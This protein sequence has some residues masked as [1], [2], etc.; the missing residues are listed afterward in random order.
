MACGVKGKRDESNSFGWG[1][2]LVRLCLCQLCFWS[3]FR[4]LLPWV[5]GPWNMSMVRKICVFV[6]YKENT[7]YNGLLVANR[8][9]FRTMNFPGRDR[10]DFQE[11]DHNEAEDTQVAFH[12]RTICFYWV[13]KYIYKCTQWFDTKAGL[14]EIQ[15]KS[16][17]INLFEK[18]IS[19][20]VNLH[21]SFIKLH[22]Y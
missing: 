5:A 6:S 13:M 10:F 15:T 17:F 11:K 1:K 19:F 4:L 9:G 14:F 16:S 8:F 12:V 20:R 3:F 7:L 22:S 18:L 2:L 21:V